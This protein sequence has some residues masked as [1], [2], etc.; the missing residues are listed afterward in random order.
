MGLFNRKD[1]KVKIV[2]QQNGKAVPITEVPDPVF[3]GK[4]LGDGVGII[5]TS[6]EV[7][8]PV[9]GTIAQ[10]A[11]TFH[12]LG[13]ESDGGLE[14]LVHLG[15]DTVKLEGQGFTCYVKE[16]QHVNAGDKLMD[17]DLDF[18]KSK[19]FN[20]ISPCIITNMDAAKDLKLFTGD[21]TA[22][23]T[24]VMTYKK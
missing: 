15:I 20:T 13:I 8:A 21:V 14:V 19:G 1:D 10:V 7:L 6:S 18:I 23:E 12:A 11:H 3:S 5:P 24:T 17:M 4:V 16:G 22:G 2:A 9:S